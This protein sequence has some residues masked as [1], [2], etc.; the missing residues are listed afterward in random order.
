MSTDVDQEFLV[1]DNIVECNVEKNG[2]H[3]RRIGMNIV[4]GCN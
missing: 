3:L 2:T 1:Y 4:P